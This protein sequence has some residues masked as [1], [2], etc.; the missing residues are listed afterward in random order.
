MILDSKFLMTDVM[1]IA[2]SNKTLFAHK[3]IKILVNIKEKY[4]STLQNLKGIIKKMNMFYY[5]KF[6]LLCAFLLLYPKVN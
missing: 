5:S 6:N 3:T 1:R 2:E 4:N